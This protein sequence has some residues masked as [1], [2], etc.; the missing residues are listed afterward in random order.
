M[1]YFAYG[2]N[3]SLA[4]LQARTPSAQRLGAFALTGYQFT[5]DQ[6]G[7][8]GSGKGN[9]VFTGHQANIVY[10]AL[11]EIAAP[12]IATLDA[13]EGLDTLYKK[14]PICVQDI[15]TSQQAEAFT[16]L[17]LVRKPD[18]V[19][20]DWYLAHIYLGALESQL[21]QDYIATYLKN[22]ATIPDKDATR[23]AREKSIHTFIKK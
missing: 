1:Q 7:P 4:R 22:V 16:Y 2:S 3:L 9:I 5:L 8:D 13:A 14:I 10:G 12:E 18:L 19:P 23:A 21:P 11:F 20:Y 15:H 6:W 17:G